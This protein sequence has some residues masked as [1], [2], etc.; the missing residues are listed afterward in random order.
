M[1]FYEDRFER[2][3]ISYSLLR[4]NFVHYFPLH[5]HRHV[6]FHYILSGTLPEMTAGD[7]RR[8]MN[9]GDLAMVFPY[10]PHATSDSLP[11]NFLCISGQSPA[12]L[13]DGCGEL[14][15]TRRPISMFVPGERLPARF[16]CLMEHIAGVY[17]SRSEKRE[18]LLASLFSVMVREAVG[19]MELEPVG[20]GEYRDSRN[21]MRRITV[22]CLE[23]LS[24]NLTLDSV[25]D[26][27]FISKY[28]ISH[29][30]SEKLNISF[31]AFINAQRVQLSCQLLSGTAKNVTDVAYE[32]GFTSIS[33]F[34]RVF[35]EYA[36]ASPREYRKSGKRSIVR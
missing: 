13:P 31:R 24:S 14:L 22:Y 33:S 15:L 28:H 12:D 20:S 36:G 8:P 1:L 4:G 30:F 7:E 26:A 21:T 9:D 27:L 10:Q 32:C 19:C 6:E 34:N 29:L 18:E 25:A 5:L 35:R 11:E 17:Y 16:D 23:N 2:D 3:N